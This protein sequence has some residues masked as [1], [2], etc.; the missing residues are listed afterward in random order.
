MPC[1]Q[2]ILVPIDFS[3]LD[4]DVLHTAAELCRRFDARAT[5]LHV[6]ESELFSVPDNPRLYDPTSI[7][8]WNEKLMRSLER[9]RHDMQANGAL[10]IDTALVEGTPYREILRFAHDGAFDLIVLGTHGRTG[11]A[12]A[13]LGSVAEKVVRLS[14]CAVMTVHKSKRSLRAADDAG[15]R[16]LT[17]DDHCGSKEGVHGSQTQHLDGTR[18]L[19]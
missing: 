17:H 6:W 16:A 5:L 18:N 11:L 2:K 1:F 12:H 7:P 3:A 15:K 10:Q 8:G 9:A 19:R 13:L 14:Q 4:P